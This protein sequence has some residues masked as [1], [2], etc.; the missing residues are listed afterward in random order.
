MSDIGVAAI[1]PRI[2][3]AVRMKNKPITTV[4]KLRAI[5]WFYAYSAGNIIFCLLGVFGPIFPLYLT[6]FGL[7]YTQIGFI[8]SLV[9][10][11]A[12][13]SL[14]S[15][16]WVMRTGPKRVLIIFYGLRKIIL[17]LL[18]LSAWIW[19]DYGTSAVFYWAA[20][21]II[22]FAVCRGIAELGFYPWL[23]EFVPNR[24]RGKVD[25]TNAVITGVIALIISLGASWMLKHVSGLAGYSYL[26]GA[27][28]LVGFVALIFVW[29]IPGGAPMPLEPA[30]KPVWEEILGPVHDRNF[31]RYLGGAALYWLGIGFLP[32]L[33]IFLKNEVGLGSDTIL[34]LDATMR[35]GILGSCWLWGWSV[36]RFGG[37]PALM[38][39]LMILIVFPLMLIVMPRVPGGNMA[40]LV[41]AYV[42]MGIGSQ[43]FNAGTSRYFYS[44]AVPPGNKNPSYYSLNYASFNLFWATGPFFAGWLL[45]LGHSIQGGLLGIAI[46]AFWVLFVLSVALLVASVWVFHRIQKDGAVRTGEFISMFIQGNPLLAF[47]STFRYRLAQDESHRISITERMGRAKNPLS[48]DDLLEALSDPSFNVRYEAVVSVAHMPPQPR[49]TAALIEI[50]RRKEPDLS[51]AAGWA[52]GRIGDRSA[53]P[54]LREMLVSEYAL[55]RSR[56]ARSLANLGDSASVPLL[57][58]AFANEAHDGIRVAYASALG[59]FRAEA[60]LEDVLALL[61]R[62]PEEALRNEAALALARMIGGEH[63]YVRLWRATRSDFGTAGAQAALAL[64]DTMA[65][66]AFAAPPVE[67]LMD[68]V[69]QH[70]AGQALDL[71][72]LSFYRLL[73]DLAQAPWEPRLRKLLLECARGLHEEKGI[74]REYFLLAF[75]ALEAGVVRL[76]RRKDSGNTSAESS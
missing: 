73:E 6:S 55:L 7:T 45:D 65:K 76:R 33:P 36:D 5:P 25:A 75:T 27:G 50:L 34:I 29:F 2:P 67:S 16:R 43:G 60:A 71:A 44:R 9:P 20:G 70:L 57:L 59:V 72:A 38:L 53:I 42:I 37:K 32:F 47:E 58:K 54:A 49:L 1:Y 13:L 39:G 21:I 46:D 61:R 52:L 48:A 23:Q 64:K 4:D 51:V 24:V 3:S 40:W 63:H 31:L 26:M 35:A 14:A 30:A 66:L 11:G 74:R 62:L 19:A 69:S 56:S 41:S 22:C 28:I 10:V 68:D 12:L 18:L 15:S 17:V 8:L